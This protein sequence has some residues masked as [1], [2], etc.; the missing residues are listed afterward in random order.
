MKI[1]NYILAF[2]LFTLS[3]LKFAKACNGYSVTLNHV[4]NCMTGG[5][6]AFSGDSQ[7]VF[8]KECNL[9]MAGCVEISK[10]FSTNQ[11][12]YTI[13]KAPMPPIEGEIDACEAVKNIK[14]T[15]LLSALKT[16]SVP[17]QCPVKAEKICSS[18]DQ[19]VNLGKYKNQLGMV[20]GTV[21]IKLEGKHDSGKSCLEINFTLAKEKR[22]G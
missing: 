13:N 1:Y 4:K 16:F 10:D 3:A 18:L 22:A 9:A 8:D 6:I 17:T 15:T 2:G 14:D 7:V 19:K 5:V 12:K 21:D 11:L 20:A